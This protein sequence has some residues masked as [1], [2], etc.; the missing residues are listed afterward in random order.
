MHGRDSV[1]GESFFPGGRNV[2]LPDLTLSVFGVSAGVRF[3]SYQLQSGED[4]SIAVLNFWCAVSKGS[5]VIARGC[6]VAS[7]RRVAANLGVV[8]VLMFLTLFWGRLG[9]DYFQCL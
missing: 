3:H 1:P 7:L 5:M 6:S 9:D 2:R 8:R 4:M